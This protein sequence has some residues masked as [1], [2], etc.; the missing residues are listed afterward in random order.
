MDVKWDLT[1]V[2]ICASLVKDDVQHLLRCAC[3]TKPI[4]LNSVI[5]TTLFLQFL[6][7]D[8]VL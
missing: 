4:V 7:L 6:N 8:I 1:V 2:L 5:A 3:W